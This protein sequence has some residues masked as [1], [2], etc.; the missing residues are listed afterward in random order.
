MFFAYSWKRPADSGA[1]LL[2]IDILA[3]LLTILASLLSVG[4][5]L[6]TVLVLLL[7]VGALLLTMKVRLI[8]TLRDCSKEA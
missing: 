1:F 6:L 8:S 2:T 7:T 5:F 3:F 4:T